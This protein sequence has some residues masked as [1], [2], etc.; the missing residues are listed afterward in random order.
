MCDV[1]AGRWINDVGLTWLV[2]ARWTAP[3]AAVGVAAK[4]RRSASSPSVIGSDRL[5]FFSVM[6]RVTASV[7]V[8][9]RFIGGICPEVFGIYSRKTGIFECRPITSAAGGW[10]WLRPNAGL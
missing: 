4:R 9:A 2:S 1:I 7:R 5:R 8:G 6:I 10:A 3:G